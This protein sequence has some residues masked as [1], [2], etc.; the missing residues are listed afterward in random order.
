MDVTSKFLLHQDSASDLEVRT[1][2][3]VV[4]PD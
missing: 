3:A 1:D 4:L 2:L